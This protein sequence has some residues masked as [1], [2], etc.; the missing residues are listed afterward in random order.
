MLDFSY[1]AIEVSADP[2]LILNKEGFII[3]GDFKEIADGITK[4]NFWGNVFK[5]KMMNVWMDEARY[6]L[7]Q[8]MIKTELSALTDFYKFKGQYGRSFEKDIYFTK[9]I[10]NLTEP[11]KK[12]VNNLPDVQFGMFS[13]TPADSENDQIKVINFFGEEVD[14]TA[15][16]ASIYLTLM[17]IEYCYSYA[18]SDITLSCM[19][20]TRDFLYDLIMALPQDEVKA[21]YRL[22]D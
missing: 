8:K 20:K 4:N 12:Y 3:H 19:G 10:F 2:Q 11:Q 13:I 18:K 5:D 9:H 16:S 21:L 1:S 15:K 7:S 22:L 6:L 17:S 14:L